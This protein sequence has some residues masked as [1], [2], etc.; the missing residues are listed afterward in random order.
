MVVPELSDRLRFAPLPEAAPQLVP[1]DLAGALLK[2]LCGLPVKQE[3]PIS[4]CQAQLTTFVRSE[5]LEF[6]GYQGPLA[7]DQWLR[8]INK[9]FCSLDTPAEYYVSFDAHRLT[10][11]A[12][13]WIHL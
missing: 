3:D 1:L 8:S 10:R 2:A 4:R 5:A 13:T 11:A 7:S 6:D 12:I 9:I